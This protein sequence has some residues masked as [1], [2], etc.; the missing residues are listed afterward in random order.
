MGIVTT[1]YN[2]HE[3]AI[4]MELYVHCLFVLRRTHATLMGSQHCLINTLYRVR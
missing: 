4:K 1:P 3:T 2:L